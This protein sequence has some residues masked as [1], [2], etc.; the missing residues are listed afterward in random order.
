MSELRPE[1]LEGVNERIACLLLLDT[2][3]SMAASS[4]INQLNQGL[5][6]LREEIEKDE[7]AKLRAEL[8]IVTFGG[9]VRLENDFATVDKFFP[10]T[11]VASGGTP[12][13]EA[14]EFGLRRL[15]DRK[16]I[17]KANSTKYWRPWVILITDGEPTDSWQNAA[18]Q[19]HS[20]AV[21]KKFTFFAIGVDPA[22][23]NMLAQV[24]PPS[25]P[26]KKLGTT[27]FR[28]LFVWLSG[29][30]SAVSRSKQGQTIPLQPTNNWEQ[31]D[32]G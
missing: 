8:A 1:L 13:G 18:A 29:S 4:K 17:Y 14:I 30:M 9:N 11:L 2:S 24:A 19:V 15:E 12:M 21:A 25:T 20:G 23:M 31:V 32:V 22:D 28:E 26:P 7:V 16:A 5:Q 6:I 10:P 27:N 3:G